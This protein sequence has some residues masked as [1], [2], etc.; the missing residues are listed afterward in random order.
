MKL[1]KTKSC[2]ELQRL[3]VLTGLE[4]HCLS[5]RDVHFGSGSGITTDSRFARFDGEDAEAAQLNPI[6][7]FQSVF[8]AIEDGVDGLLGF[9]LADPRPFDDLIDKVEFDH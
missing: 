7:A 1:L 2:D 8:H 9:R 4:S 5:G 6:V 3:Q